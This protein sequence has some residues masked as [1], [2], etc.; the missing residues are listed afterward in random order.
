MRCLEPFY[1]NGLNKEEKY[2]Q[3]PVEGILTQNVKMIAL[4]F[5]AVSICEKEYRVK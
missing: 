1:P 3:P 5:N 4:Y 2:W